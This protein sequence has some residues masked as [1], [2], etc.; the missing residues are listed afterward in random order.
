MTMEQCIFQYNTLV[1]NGIKRK[2]WLHNYKDDINC[3]GKKNNNLPNEHLL[4]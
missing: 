3:I 2:L 1:D 4:L